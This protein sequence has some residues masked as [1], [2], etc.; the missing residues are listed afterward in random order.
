MN[1]L[2]FLAEMFSVITYEPLDKM[3]DDFMDFMAAQIEEK[4]DHR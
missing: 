1:V 4:E 2:A 3:I